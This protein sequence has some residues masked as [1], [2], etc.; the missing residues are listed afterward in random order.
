LCRGFWQITSTA[1]PRR[2][3][4][5]FSHMGFTDA[6]TFI[7]LGFVSKKDACRTPGDGPQA[8]RIGH[9]ADQRR[10]A[11][12][13][14]AAAQGR[15]RLMETVCWKVGRFWKGWGSMSS[16]DATT[17]LLRSKQLGCGSSSQ[18]PNP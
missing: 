1:P 9:R 11:T 14:S 10:I 2:M 12:A 7:A 4:L 3:T 18:G 8:Q 13:P 5:H 15:S 17:E 16:P 6:R